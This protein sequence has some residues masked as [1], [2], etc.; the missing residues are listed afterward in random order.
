MT[1]M[2]PPPLNVTLMLLW[3][4][5]IRVPGGSASGRSVRRA[6]QGIEAGD[7]LMLAVVRTNRI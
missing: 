3:H 5:R 7:E 6:G 1:A 2:N 4:P